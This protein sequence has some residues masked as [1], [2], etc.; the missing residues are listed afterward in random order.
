[1]FLALP[2]LGHQCDAAQTNLGLEII[3]DQMP[4]RSQSTVSVPS[5]EDRG[6]E[7]LLD[8]EEGNIIEIDYLRRQKVTEK[9][10]ES[11]QETRNKLAHKIATLQRVEELLATHKRNRFIVV[12]FLTVALVILFVIETIYSLDN[13][14]DWQLVFLK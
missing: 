12:L 1:M 6:T 13:K 9:A 7:K 14:K 11:S 10:I 8:N 5:E 3:V 4:N 2:T